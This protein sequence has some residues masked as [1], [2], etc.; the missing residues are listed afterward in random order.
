LWTRLQGG[1]LTAVGLAI[2]LGTAALSGCAGSGQGGDAGKQIRTE[3]DQTD[4]DRR[5]KVRLELAEGYFSRGQYNTALDEVKLA[6]AAKPELI[7]AYNLRGLIY[8]AMGE[9]ALAEESFRRALSIDSKDADALH[10]YGWFLC[11]QK[12]L[13]EA[14]KQFD[15]VLA[16]PT[17]RSATRTLLAKGVCQARGGFWLEA[18]GTLQRAF[19]L[20]PSSPVVAVNLAEVLLRRGDLD[21]ARFYIRRVNSIAEQVGPQTLWLELRI[22]RRLGNTQSVREVGDKLLQRFPQSLEARAFENGR[23]DE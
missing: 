4:N 3:S 1:A 6:F 10:N 7:E 16:L 18:E 21:R 5:A 14:I 17:Y 11:Q 22:E 12:R 9:T 15:L 20:D 2:W 13:S 23:F 19:E 8:A